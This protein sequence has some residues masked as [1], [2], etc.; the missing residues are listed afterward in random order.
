MRQ[1]IQIALHLDVDYDLARALPEIPGEPGPDGHPPIPAIE[2]IAESFA[3][4]L[5]ASV[6]R[7]IVRDGSDLANL[8]AVT[9]SSKVRFGKPYDPAAEPF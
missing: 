4:E 8:G 1:T 2:M 6:A 9:L 5:R 7:E 3:S